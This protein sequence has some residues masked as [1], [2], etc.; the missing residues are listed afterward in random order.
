[1]GEPLLTENPN[2]FCLFPI[3]HNDI[4]KNYKTQLSAF[5][6]VE[7]VQ[8][9]R[10]YPDFMT[11]TNNERYFIKMILAFFA[12]ADGIVID[13]LG[14]RFLREVKCAELTLAYGFQ[15]F[16]EGIHS[17][18]YSLLIDTLIKDK[19]EKHKL[20]NAFEN[21]ECVKLKQDWAKRWIADDDASFAHRV[22]AFAC[23]EGIFFSGAFCAI[24]WLKKRNKMPGLTL[25][26]EFISRDEGMH[27]DLA[28]LVYS[29]LEN[30]LNKETIEDIIREAVYIEDEF[31]N[32]SLPCRL[33]GM[34]ATLMSQYIKFVAD[35]LLLQL[36]YDKIYNVSNP[37]SFMEMISMERKGNFFETP[38]SDYS[39]N[40]NTRDDTIFEVEEEF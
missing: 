8:L 30:K 12:G 33:I 17:E 5:W 3:T 10:D 32:Q 40:Q 16:M 34:N 25:S 26:N 2:R 39:K 22:V 19:E 6:I 35:R 36:G 29:K 31:I 14:A 18:M 20:F 37:F 9:E 23:V 4:W 11:L 28:C 27:T 1:M 13:N 15:L 7:E 24:F 38:I 21:F